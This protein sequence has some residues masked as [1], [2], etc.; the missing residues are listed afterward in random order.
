MNA[1][2]TKTILLCSEEALSIFVHKKRDNLDLNS[3]GLAGYNKSFLFRV[4]LQVPESFADKQLYKS[5]D[6][7][8]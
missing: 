8:A 2:C 7:T 3:K 5:T 4:K 6:T 1:L